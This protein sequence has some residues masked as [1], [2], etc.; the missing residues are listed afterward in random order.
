MYGVLTLAVALLLFALSHLLTA[1]AGVPR[2]RW[3]AWGVMIVAEAAAMLTHNTATILVPLALNGAIG[4]LWL[5]QRWG[6]NATELPGLQQRHFYR[7]WVLSQVAALLLWS[8]WAMG[9]IRQVTVVD[10]DFWIEPP[11][12]WTVWLAL[13]NFSYAYLPA[14]L[15]YRDYL[16]WFAL[17]LVMLG[18]WL[19]RRSEGVTWLLLGLWLIPP[20]V[21]LIAS[22]RR[23]IFYDRTIIWATLPYFL[24]VARG[25]VMP[26]RVPAWL[27][28]GWLAL[29]LT[30]LCLLCGL[31]ISTYFTN[32]EKEAWDEVAAIVADNAEVQEVVL[33][34]AS[35]SELPFDYYY[36]QLE[37]GQAPALAYR[38]LPVDLFDA[39]KLEPPMT[40]ASV[41]RL[42][43][44]IDGRERV[45]LVYSHWWY[46]DPHGLILRALEEHFEVRQQYQ[47]PGIRLIEYVR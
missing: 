12:L 11:T 43:E 14:W 16:A 2:A 33:F 45:W 32:F 8:P 9:F 26:D 31:G 7:W 40:E 35:W 22:L 29:T 15:E 4:G 34:H 39:G 37:K 6:W 23:P 42:L 18:I 44:L 28:C 21:E 36:R 47:W 1:Q 20:A 38:G 25:V 10:G 46:T 3:W 27:R 24:L 17:G 41:Q 19:W 13:G 30:V 5:A